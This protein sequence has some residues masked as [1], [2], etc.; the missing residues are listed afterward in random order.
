M[1]HLC[2][3]ASLQPAYVAALAPGADGLGPAS[4]RAAGPTSRVRRHLRS[5]FRSSSAAARRAAPSQAKGVPLK[6]P[7]PCGASATAW[8]QRTTRHAART[9]GPLRPLGPSPCSPGA[10]LGTAADRTASQRSGRSRTRPLAAHRTRNPRTGSRATRTHHHR[11]RLHTKHRPSRFTM[12]P[13]RAAS[14]ACLPRVL[15]RC[16]PLS[17]SRVFVTT[18]PAS[19]DTPHQ[20]TSRTRSSHPVAA[21]ARRDRNGMCR[22]TGRRP[23]A[24]P[25]ATQHRNADRSAALH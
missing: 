24:Y 22:R 23:S 19:P 2:H 11:P 3:T 7:D 20:R 9:C 21:A 16:K 17:Q 25:H 15:R 6:T 8:P 12:C 14:T 10:T 18:R 13:K 5:R 1:T 4:P